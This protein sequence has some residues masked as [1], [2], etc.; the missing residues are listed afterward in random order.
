ML[1]VKYLPRMPSVHIFPS[2]VSALYWNPAGNG[3]KNLDYI[4][5]GLI[6]S[7]QQFS[8]ALKMWITIGGSNW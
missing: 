1:N 2:E 8:Y 7:I 5:C 4:Y 3:C 6:Q